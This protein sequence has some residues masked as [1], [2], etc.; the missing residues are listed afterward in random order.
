MPA[1]IDGVYVVQP[2]RVLAWICDSTGLDGGAAFSNS[3][4]EWRFS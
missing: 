3:A 2:E 4:T 1:S